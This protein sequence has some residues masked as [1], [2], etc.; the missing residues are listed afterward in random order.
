MA[1]A[2]NFGEWVT[3]PDGRRIR[4]LGY[5]DGSIRFRIEG[6]P[7]VIS[8]AFLTKGSTGGA[9]IKLVPADKV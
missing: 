2:N 6:A 8:E 4:V 3:L 1:S 7:Y 9:I 5:E